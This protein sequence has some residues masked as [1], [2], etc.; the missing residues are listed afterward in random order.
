MFNAD[1]LLKPLVGENPCGEEIV[2]STEIDEI[3]EARRFDDPSLSQGEWV[4]DIKTADWSFVVKQ[5]SK[6]IAEKSKDLRFA[7]WLTEANAKI[8]HFAGLTE[9]YRLIA[10][11][12]QQYWEVLHPIETEADDYEQRIG[13]IS[14]LISQSIQLMKEMPI[15]ENDEAHYSSVDFE[16]AY[17]R[18]SQVPSE[19]IPV[20]EVEAAKQA[21]EQLEKARKS[22]SKAFY[23]NLLAEQENCAQALN[24]LE[25]AI[26]TRLG[27]DGPGFSAVKDTLDQ[28]RSMAKRFAADVGV[29]ERNQTEPTQEVATEVNTIET[30]EQTPSAPSGTVQNRAQAIQQLRQIANFFKSTEPHSPV[31]YLAE[32]AA[33]WGEM[34][35]HEWLSTV[36]KDN[37]ALSHVEELLGIQATNEIQDTNQE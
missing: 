13:N 23:T 1:E 2:F 20:G 29:G 5:S 12:F 10:G 14:W 26:D 32:K 24:A 27:V 6:L 33:T 18:S 35:L 25:E 37:G 34:P 22:T 9:G 30:T 19:D 28:V 3:I 15:A 16:T 8:D 36:I 17:K 4:T 21:L 7:V 11:L 31:A